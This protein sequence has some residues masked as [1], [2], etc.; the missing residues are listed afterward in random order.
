[1]GSGNDTVGEA[2]ILIGFWG[3][4]LGYPLLQF[5]AIRRMHGGWRFL[6][7]LPLVL[8]AIVFTFTVVA[9][10]QESNLWPIVLIF[11]SPLVLVYLAALLGVHAFTLRS[12]N[13]KLDAYHGGFKLDGRFAAS[14]MSGEG[15]LAL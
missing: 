3:G 5:F 9:L 7:F 4:V 8:M 14:W 1:M 13:D 2:I 10:Y 6:A 11:A 12:K 15:R